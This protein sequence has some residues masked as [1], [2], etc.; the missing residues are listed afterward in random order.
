MQNEEYRMN[1][2]IRDSGFGIRENGP[3]S[4]RQRRIETALV[5]LAMLAIAAA[6]VL[7]IVAVAGALDIPVEGGCR[8]APAAGLDRQPLNPPDGKTLSESE[9]SGP[10]GA[11]PAGHF[12]AWAAPAGSRLWT[13]ICKVESGGDKR[14]YAADEDAAGIAQIRPC[15]LADLERL[16]LGRFTPDD[17]WDPAKSRR[18]FDIYVRHYGARLRVAAGRRPTDEDLARI[19]NGGPNGWRKPST[20][21]YWQRVEEECGRPGATNLR[22]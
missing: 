3:L 18:I 22:N 4:R 16:G 7:T 21:G 9:P 6:V 10:G 12:L 15:V 2:G 11:A 5:I 13:A 8:Q 20:A 1:G 17:R 19:W 14:A